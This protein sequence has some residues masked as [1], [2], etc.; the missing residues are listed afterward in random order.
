MRSS[1]IRHKQEIIRRIAGDLAR[2]NLTLVQSTAE[3]FRALDKGVPDLILLTALIS[4]A[5]EAGLL[6]YL[7]TLPDSEHLEVL[8]TPILGWPR[9]TTKKTDRGICGWFARGAAPSQTIACDPRVFA[10]RIS[11]SL[12]RC[13]GH[14]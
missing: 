8:F 12:Q 1:P 13:S 4:P 11:W 9:E 6:A 14:T 5:D 10:E 2:A 3:L 7:R